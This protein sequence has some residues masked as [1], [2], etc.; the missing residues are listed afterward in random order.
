M[1]MVVPSWFFRL[2]LL[3][4]DVSIPSVIVPVSIDHGG[5]FSLEEALFVVVGVFVGWIFLV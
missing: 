5:N 1:P 4:P 3:A 2:L